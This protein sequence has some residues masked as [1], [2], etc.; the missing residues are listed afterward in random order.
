MQIFNQYIEIYPSIP[1]TQ[2]L[3][4]MSEKQSARKCYWTIHLRVPTTFSFR[5]QPLI[6]Y[7][8]SN[9]E[10][11][12]LQLQENNHQVQHLIWTEPLTDQPSLDQPTIITV[13]HSITL[14]LQGLNRQWVIRL[15]HQHSRLFQ[16]KASSHARKTPCTSSLKKE[17]T[18]KEHTFLI[19]SGGSVEYT[20]LISRFRTPQQVHSPI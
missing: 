14:L 8:L 5:T 11:E 19:H 7:G 13:S 15:L 3:E 20:E 12:N 17:V 6:G 1:K 18:V 4:S 16:S 9:Q 10:S 2:I